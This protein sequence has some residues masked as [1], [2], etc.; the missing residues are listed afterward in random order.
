MIRWSKRILIVFL[1]IPLLFGLWLLLRAFVCDYFTIPTFSM[2]PTLKPGDEV[3]VNKLLMGARIYN[4]FHFDE[5]G[6]ALKSWR[7][8][9]IKSISHNDIVVFNYPYHNWQVNFV[10]NHVF[11]KRVMA[12]P[13]DTISIVDGFYRNNNYEEVLGLEDEQIKYADLPESECWKKYVQTYP[14]DKN[15]K[16]TAYHFGPMYIPR[17]GDVMNITPYEATLYKMILAWETGE[18]ILFGQE[19]SILPSINGNMI[20]ISWQEI[21]FWILMTLVFGELFQRNISL[22]L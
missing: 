8:K 10:I 7:T 5:K 2:Y 22:E 11:C 20:I 16:W 21:M 4:D 14:Y 1:F 3:I 15:I 13:G 17:K 18:A 9:G 12:L 6:V 19:T